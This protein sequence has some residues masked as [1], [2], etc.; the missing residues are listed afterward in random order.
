MADE[1]ACLARVAIAEAF[2]RIGGVD[3]L[4]EWIGEDPQNRRIFLSQIY[5]KILSHQPEPPAAV[6]PAGPLCWL[7]P[8]ALD[9]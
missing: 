5:P 8:S 9:G 2:A 1:P 7:L 6:E 3:A 4:V